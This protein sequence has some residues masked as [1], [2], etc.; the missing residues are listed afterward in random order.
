M[1]DHYR[2]A[3]LPRYLD[4]FKMGVRSLASNMQGMGI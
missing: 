2:H 1:G 4:E 3:A